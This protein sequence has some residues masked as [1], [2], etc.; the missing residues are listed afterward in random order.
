MSMRLKTSAA[1]A[2]R[3]AS[4]I[5]EVRDGQFVALK[6]GIGTDRVVRFLVERDMPVYEIAYEEET[7]ANFYLSL[8]KKSK[9]E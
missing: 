6:D 2:L 3:E 8:M 4:L 7:L 1:K 9:K 5:D